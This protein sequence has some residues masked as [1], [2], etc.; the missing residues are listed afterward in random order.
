MIH[1]VADNKIG[2]TPSYLPIAL[3]C[4]QSPSAC[5]EPALPKVDLH[6]PCLEESSSST[7]HLFGIAFQSMSISKERNF[8]FDQQK[9]EQERKCEPLREYERCVSLRRLSQRRHEGDFEELSPSPRL[10]NCHSGEYQK[11]KAKKK[12]RTLPSWRDPTIASA[13]PNVEILHEQSQSLSLIA[14]SLSSD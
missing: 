9:T 7:S 11:G 1:L 3:K 8:S 12:E 13:H 5:T 6:A 10:Y 4:Q 2:C 14:L